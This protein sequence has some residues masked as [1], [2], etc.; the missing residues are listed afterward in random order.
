ME[1]SHKTPKK[2]FRVC[3]KNLNLLHML[4]FKERKQHLT[5]LIF[6]FLGQSDRLQLRGCLNL[7]FP[8]LGLF[9]LRSRPSNIFL[10]FLIHFL[11][12]AISFCVII[13]V[14][15]AL[16]FTL[17]NFFEVGKLKVKIEINS[18]YETMMHKKLRARLCSFY[19]YEF[20]GCLCVLS[21][22]RFGKSKNKSK[23]L[24]VPKGIKEDMCSQKPT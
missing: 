9:L 2:S 3:N 6:F 11:S 16:A 10:F 23:F 14:M 1:S 5:K 4:F 8:A 17:Q 19:L 24:Q 22:D 12:P 7:R 20:Y 21:I 18:H 13:R 15:S